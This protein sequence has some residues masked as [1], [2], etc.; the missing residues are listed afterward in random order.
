MLIDLFDISSTGPSPKKTEFPLASALG[1]VHTFLISLV[2]LFIKLLL[3]IN[4]KFLL[5]FQAPLYPSDSLIK[6]V[7]PVRLHGKILGNR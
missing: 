3:Q 2:N 7:Q 4:T 1:T 6:T 5:S